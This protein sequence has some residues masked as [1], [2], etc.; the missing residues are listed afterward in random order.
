MCY[1]IIANCQHTGYQ[2]WSLFQVWHAHCIAEP[3]LANAFKLKKSSF[4]TK[5]I[6]IELTVLTYFYF[7]QKNILIELA[8]YSREFVEYEL[9]NTVGVTIVDKCESVVDVGIVTWN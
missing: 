4:Q 3:T 2:K 5:L 7:K 6:S 8:E 9:V 1:C